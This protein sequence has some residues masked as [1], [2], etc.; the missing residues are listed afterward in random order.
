MVPELVIQPNTTANPSAH[1]RVDYNGFIPIL[2]EAVN[3][4][5]TEQS[6]VSG[7]ETK[8]EVLKMHNEALQSDL[9]VLRATVTEQQRLLEEQRQQIQHLF[10]RVQALETTSTAN[11]DHDSK[12]R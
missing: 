11:R 2:L 3:E 5:Q 8:T 7:L 4:L 9:V 12:M 10:G 1:K 6:G